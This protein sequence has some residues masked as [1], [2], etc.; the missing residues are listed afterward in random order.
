MPPIR[1]NAPITDGRQKENG[2]IASPESVPI[3]QNILAIN[4]LTSY[5]M[6]PGLGM[7]SSSPSPI[8]YTTWDPSKTLGPNFTKHLKPKN[9]VRSIHMYVWNFKK[10]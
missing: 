4:D 10:S 8:Q 7:H 9:F 3:H 1:E 2:R 5:H 6:L